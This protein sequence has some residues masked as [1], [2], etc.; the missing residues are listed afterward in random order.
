M[1]LKAI[2]TGTIAEP[3]LRWTP[4]EK[5][6]LDLRLIATATM[7]DK[8]TGKWNDVGEPLWLTAT[9]WDEEA[10][11]LSE[12]LSKGDRVT[13]EG[14]LVIETFKRRDG[15]ESASHVLQYPR[16]LG[17]IPAR[18]KEMNSQSAG[19]APF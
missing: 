6:V 15:S 2:A 11:R 4:Q 10:Q 5:A 12:A 14:T 13:V 17:V 3:V 9:F 8:S 16:F 19:A 18:R 7:R 1:P